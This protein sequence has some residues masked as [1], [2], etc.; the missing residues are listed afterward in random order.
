MAVGSHP[1]SP[2]VPAYA[3]I[4]YTA[5]GASPPFRIASDAPQPLPA[6]KI[7]RGALTIRARAN[8]PKLAELEHFLIN[9]VI[10]HTGYPPEILPL[11][12]DLEADLGIDSIKEAQLFDELA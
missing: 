9:F 4:E 1:I 5:N 7:G 10:E 3:S 11:D 6:A 12:A 8:A 2:P